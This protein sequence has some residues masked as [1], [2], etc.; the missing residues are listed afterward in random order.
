MNLNEESLRK[1]IIQYMNDNNKKNIEMAEL[2]GM[3]SPSMFSQYR[4]G[5]TK[6]LKAEYLLNFIYNAAIDLEIFLNKNYISSTAPTS[7]YNTEE[8]RCTN[9]QCTSDKETLQEKIELLTKLNKL[10]EEKIAWLQEQKGGH[11]GKSN[12]GDVEESISETG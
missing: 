12:E 7:P 11:V 9:P 3:S 6:T 8:G 5:I 4:N 10:Q 1:F 2:F